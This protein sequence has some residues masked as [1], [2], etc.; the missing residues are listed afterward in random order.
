MIKRLLIVLVLA[1]VGFGL[2]PLIWGIQDAQLLSPVAAHYVKN[3]VQELGAANLVT[4]VVVSYRGLDTFGEV[5]VLFAATAGITMLLG[6]GIVN[7]EKKGSLKDSGARQ[8]G[9]RRE[10]RDG[11]ELLKTGAALLFPMMFLFGIYIFMNGHITPGGGFQG[12][13]VIASAVVLLLLAA[14][15]RSL[16]TG[17]LHAAEALSGAA[18]AA[19]GLLGLWLAA[20]FLDPRFLPSGEF[21][22]FFSAGAIPL[23]YSL[24]GMKVGSELTGVVDSLRRRA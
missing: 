3:G 24:I 19:V 2:F 6:A 8:P 5:A 13:V 1:A 11:S 12:G 21:G 15:D 20:G 4:A 9:S 10:R 23:I 7:T 22:A 18:Y 14:S 16:R 17:L